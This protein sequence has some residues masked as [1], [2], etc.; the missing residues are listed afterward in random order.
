M[1]AGEASDVP[2]YISTNC[3]FVQNKER[4]TL[5]YASDD[6]LIEYNENTGKITVHDIPALEFVL[7]S[8]D[9]LSGYLPSNTTIVSKSNVYT[10]S[11]TTLQKIDLKTLQ[12]TSKDMVQEGYE[13]KTE[14]ISGAENSDELTFAGLRYKDG[15]NVVGTIDSDFNVHVFENTLSS[16]PIMNLIRIN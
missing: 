9:K 13:I 2:C 5:M 1:L 6:H 16:T 8:K 11:G 12:L 15:M 10:L 14:N 3:D 7:Q 4:G